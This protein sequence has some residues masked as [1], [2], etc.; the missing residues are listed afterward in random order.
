VAA[1]ASR[2]CDVR[3]GARDLIGP[4]QYSVATF[5]GANGEDDGNRNS[6]D[7]PVSRLGASAEVPKPG[8]DIVP[9]G[10]SATKEYHET[11]EGA[12]APPALFLRAHGRREN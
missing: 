11:G 5:K 12:I 2:A 10:A 6:A 3:S 8:N 1:R 9:A 4:I 7:L